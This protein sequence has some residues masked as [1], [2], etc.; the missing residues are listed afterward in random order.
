MYVDPHNL[1]VSAFVIRIF[2][3]DDRR[4]FEYEE[5]EG[6]NLHLQAHICSINL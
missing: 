5:Y 3:C 6:Q 1:T 2:P 4:E